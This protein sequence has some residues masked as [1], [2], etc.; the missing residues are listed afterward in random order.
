M[1]AEI[2]TA[3]G[4]IKKDL[5]AWCYGLKPRIQ[6]SSYRTQDKVAAI[7]GI[8]F[9]RLSRIIRNV[10]QPSDDEIRKIETLLFQDEQ[11]R[12]ASNGHADIQKI[13]DTSRPDIDKIFGRHF[14]SKSERA[15]ISLLSEIAK[16]LKSIDEKIGQEIL[17]QK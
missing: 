5:P 4:Q 17:N 6:I 15:T 14:C 7:I 16:T 3:I 10:T 8:D 12:V 9:G 11:K 1:E 13:I 2:K